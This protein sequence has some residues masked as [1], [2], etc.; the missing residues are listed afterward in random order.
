MEVPRPRSWGTGWRTTSRTCSDVRNP[1]IS[2]TLAGYGVTSLAGLT[3]AQV[4]TV[5]KN[6]WNPSGTTKNTYAQAFAVALG[7]YADTSSFGGNA[8]AQGFGF[9]VTP[10]GSSGAT[11]NVGG[12]GSAFGVSNNTSLSVYRILQTL[13]TNF[14]PSTGSFYGGNQSLD[15]RRQQRR[16][17]HQHD[18]RHHQRPD[19]D[20]P[21][22]RRLHAGPDPGRLRHQ[23]PVA[24]TAPARPSP[25]STPTT[26][27]PSSRPSTRS[28]RSS[29][30]TDS[31]PTLYDQYGPASSFLTVLNQ[32]GQTDLAAR[33]RPERGRHRQLGDG[34][35]ARRR[36]DPRHRP[37][38]PDRPGR[39]Q[40]PVAV[41]PDG[42]RGHRRQ[43]SP[44]C[45][46][47]R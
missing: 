33:D 28:T 41:R 24:R 45:R 6:L 1:Y 12:N 8:T 18:R 21:P 44:A 10:A 29:A 2:S 5:Y 14:S 20:P 31:G 15:Q 40:Q 25:S 36:M 9:N 26:I 34:G 19:P 17:R 39:G 4:A 35:G 27:R 16:Q 32:S 7:I 23:Q 38:G 42:R 11:Y 22:G 13:N 46:S 43:P 30:L 47:C 37:R 3:N